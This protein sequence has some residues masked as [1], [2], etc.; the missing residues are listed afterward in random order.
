MNKYT[1]KIPFVKRILYFLPALAIAVLI[2]CFSAQP[3]TDSSGLSRTVTEDLIRAVS[4]TFGLSLTA[5]QIVTAVSK[6]EHLVRKLA[7]FTEYAVF[8]LALTCG[9]R[10]NGLRGRKLFFTALC[11]LALYAGS[12]EFHQLFVPGRSS[13]LRDVCIDTAG[14][15]VG[16]LL[17]L[18]QFHPGQNRSVKSDKTS[19]IVLL[20]TAG[21]L[22]SAFLRP[23]EIHASSGTITFDANGGTG[24]MDAVQVSDGDTLP[25]STFSRYGYIFR[26]WSTDPDA[27]EAELDDQDTVETGTDETL[28]AV[29]EPQ[30]YIIHFDG[31]GVTNNSAEDMYAYYGTSIPLEKNHFFR[32]G[33]RFLGW[34]DTATG[35]RYS[36]EQSV[37]NLQ[38][39]ST[40][41]TKIRTIDNGT[42]TNSKYTFRSTQGSCVYTKD[43]VRYLLT[44][45]IVNDSA[46]NKGDT[47]H[48][49][50]ILCKY[51]LDTGELVDSVRNLA[52]DHGNSICYCPDNDHIYIAE[53]G[54]YE[55]YPSGVMELDGDLNYITEYNFP[56]LTH[57]WAISCSDGYF[58]VIGRNSGSRNSFCVLNQNMQTLSITAVDDYYSGYSSQGIAADNSFLYAIS[59][60]FKT[61]DWKTKQRISVFSHAGEYLGVFTIDIPEE[62]EDISI[63]GDYMYLSTNEH[64]QSTIYQAR[65]PK[66]TLHA[67]WD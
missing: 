56:L 25:A 11:T 24:S 19:T 12:D 54:A 59:A 65:I 13:Q 4:G 55:G 36:N 3:S 66:E 44:A 21:L 64:A 9:Y 30:L 39:G 58:Y 15:A 45:S 40:Y 10:R 28:Y 49:E 42:P 60:G 32:Q 20:L 26:G 22:L 37:L 48:Y 18:K 34:I 52:F 51:N 67:I 47:S 57:I 50:N 62:V 1:H 6:Y 53:G 43:G 46:Y 61:Y 5:A 35:T 8:G 14:G 33:H 63:D 7:H 16:T 38:S 31:S 27:S 2:F 29:W 17:G 23:L 41:S